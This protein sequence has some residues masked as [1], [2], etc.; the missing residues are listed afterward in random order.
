MLECRLTPDYS[1]NLQSEGKCHKSDATGQVSVGIYATT[2]PECSVTCICDLH[3]QSGGESS[4][5]E[6]A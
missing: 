1:S 6:M 4:W 5:R 2:R 3:L